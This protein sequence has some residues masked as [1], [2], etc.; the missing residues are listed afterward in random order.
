MHL[1]L[2]DPGK[3]STDLQYPIFIEGRDTPLS[4]WKIIREIQNEIDFE[5][6]MCSHYIPILPLMRYRDVTGEIREFTHEQ[7][8]QLHEGVT[9]ANIAN[10]KP[11]RAFAKAAPEKAMETAA[12]LV[13][14]GHLAK[15]FTINP[16]SCVEIGHPS[17]HLIRIYETD[18]AVI[19]RLQL[20]DFPSDTEPSVTIWTEQELIGRFGFVPE[21]LD[22]PIKAFLCLLAASIVRDF[23][24]LENRTRQ[25]TYQTRTEKKNGNASVKGKTEN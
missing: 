17:L 12:E 18:K 1:N 11:F 13:K 14:S 8:M 15:H 20:D 23:W 3:A 16:N 9:R 10:L 21:E 19:C 5:F 6:T 24:V 2:M 7:I 4:E 25:R 22:A